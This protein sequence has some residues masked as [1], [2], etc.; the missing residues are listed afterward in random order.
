[1]VRYL[2][3]AILGCLYIIGSIVIVRSA[4]EAHRDRLTKTKTAAPAPDDAFV[5]Q[6]SDEQKVRE[7]VRDPKIAA[8]LRALPHVQFEVKDDEGWFGPKFPD[9][10]DE[11]YFESRGTIKDIAQL[12]QIFDLFADSL[13]RLCAIG[14]A[15]E[16]EPGVKPK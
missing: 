2:A 7:L 12:K 6:G 14:S 13:H 15:Y 11:L 3:A 5:F 8:A 10:V 9:G 1:M 16:R 4:G